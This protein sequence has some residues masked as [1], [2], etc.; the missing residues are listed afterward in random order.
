MTTNF[1]ESN[2]TGVPAAPNTASA[3]SSRYDYFQN[4]R[5][6]KLSRMQMISDEWR[7]SAGRDV[8]IPKPTVHSKSSDLDK[9]LNMPASVFTMLDRGRQREI[10]DFYM[11][12]QWH[13]DQYKDMT[14]SLHPCD[15]FKLADY[16]YQC[17][18]DLTSA[19]AKYPPSYVKYKSPQVLPLLNLSGDRVELLPGRSLA[20]RY[21][22][23]S[24]STYQR[25]I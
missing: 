13:R 9:F 24:M 11:T 1:L 14:G 12:C 6:E 8:Y 4:Y 3:S 16:M 5:N 17:P 20:G 23:G 19:S 15:Y 25:I 22:P 18:H 21:D 2:F 10:D 7:S